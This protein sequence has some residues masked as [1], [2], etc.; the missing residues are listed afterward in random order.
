[1][2][3]IQYSKEFTA[4]LLLNIKQLS[5]FCYSLEELDECGMCRY[6]S[7]DIIDGETIHMSDCPWFKSMMIARQFHYLNET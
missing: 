5:D 3:G 4:Y 7:S 6:C 1:M 2:E